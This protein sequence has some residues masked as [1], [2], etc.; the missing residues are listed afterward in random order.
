MRTMKIGD[1]GFFY[2]SNIGLEI[3]GIVEVCSEVHPDSTSNNL[4]E[5]VD[6]KAVCDMPY[7]VSL[8]AAKAS[9]ELAN[10]VLVTNSRLSVQPVSKT[11]WNHICAMG[12][13]NGESLTPL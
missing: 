7:P 4:W 12:G 6:V 5:C 2:H 8:T 3:V 9:P 10:M 11:Q 13:L 1:L